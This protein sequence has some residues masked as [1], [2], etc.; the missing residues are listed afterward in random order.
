MDSLG[1]SLSE[2]AIAELMLARSALEQKN[3][4]I[5]AREAVIRDLLR[6][7]RALE[8]ELDQMNR[9]VPAAEH[10]RERGSAE[11]VIEDIVRLL[12]KYERVP[13]ATALETHT[14]AIAGLGAEIVELLKDRLGLEVIEG[15]PAEIDPHIHRVIEVTKSPEN[16]ERAVPLSKGYRLG[17]KVISP[18]DIR[19]IEGGEA[20]EDGNPG[21]GEAA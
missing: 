11:G 13:A 20:Q 3:E 15:A 17:K 9:A 2:E 4:T 6:K 19:V 14:P 5:D 18:M 1:K 16:R 7:N 8:R 21:S 10:P 12:V